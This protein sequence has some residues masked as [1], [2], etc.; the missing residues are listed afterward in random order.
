MTNKIH[1]YFLMLPFV[2]MNLVIG[3]GY[4]YAAEMGYHYTFGT[5]CLLIFMVIINCSDLSETSRNTVVT[6]VAAAAI[7]TA[8]PLLSMNITHCDEYLKNRAHYERIE[9]ALSSIP[10]DAVVISDTNYLPH[11]ASRKEIYLLSGEDF[12]TAN[13]N[14]FT[15]TLNIEMYS[16]VLTK[17]NITVSVFANCTHDEF[18]SLLEE[19]VKI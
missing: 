1:R 15:V 8:V 16:A 10:E 2:I 17:D 6:A 11:V 9:A 4:R 5:A 7:I 19:I 14:V 12:V 3:S 13:G 18:I